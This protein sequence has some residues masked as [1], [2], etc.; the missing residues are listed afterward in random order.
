M[1]TIDTSIPF[2]GYT[3]DF[4]GTIARGTQAGMMVNDARRQN[5]LLALYQA[6]GPQIA[7]GNPNALNTL[8]QFDPQAALGVQDARQA[9]DARSLSMQATQQSMEQQ[10]QEWAMTLS[11]EERAQ[12]AAEGEAMLSRIVSAT[13]ETWPALAAEMGQPNA[14]YSMRDT[15]INNMLPPLE[16]LKRMDAQAA[17]DS[18]NP[19]RYRNVEGVGLVDLAAPGQPAPVDLGQPATPPVDPAAVADLRDEINK[20]PAVRSFITMA[21]AYNRISSVATDQSPAG[22]IALIFGFMRMLDPASVVR[23]GEFATAQNAAGIPDQVR[24]AYNRALS[25]ER[26]TPEQRADFLGQAQS[27]Y[28]GAYDQYKGVVGQYAGI[29]SR[30]GLPLEDVIVKYGAPAS[31]PAA[32]AGDN[33]RNPLPAVIPS[34]QIK[35]MT[36]AEIGALTLDQIDAAT[37]SGLTPEQWDAIEGL[38]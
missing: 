7:A 3:P 16:A 11:A 22:D 34:N 10:A 32:P 15:M 19:D 21:D 5:D 8:A 20:N 27:V 12:K 29:A 4:A 36:P 35:A 30:L 9:M 33:P 38:Q 24:N 13:P 18:F 1:A 23:E 6:Q 31:Q 37:L 14:P 17:G 25:G 28:N 2:S 26:L